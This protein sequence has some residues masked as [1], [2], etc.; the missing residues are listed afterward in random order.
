MMKKSK[1]SKKQETFDQALPS[2]EPS[3]VLLPDMNP[4]PKGP[5][6]GRN[7]DYSYSDTDFKLFHKK[8]AYCKK[9]RFLFPG[10]IDEF[11]LHRVVRYVKHMKYVRSLSFENNVWNSKGFIMRF[12]QRLRQVNS[13]AIEFKFE[14][15][16]SRAR[17]QKKDVEAIFKSFQRDMLVFKIKFSHIHNVQEDFLFC[18][19]A[20]MTQFLRTAPNLREFSFQISPDNFDSDRS[21][22]HIQDLLG[23]RLKH[24]IE[25]MQRQL[26]NLTRIESFTFLNCSAFYKSIFDY[27]LQKFSRLSSLQ[28]LEL[29]GLPVNRIRNIVDEMKLNQSL[30]S[31]TFRYV[32]NPEDALYAVTS[33]PSLKKFTIRE[34]WMFANKDMP[35]LKTLD[36]TTINV[37]SLN[38]DL[39]LDINDQGDADFLISFI[40]PFRKLTC[41]KLYIQSSFDCST[42]ITSINNIAKGL[43]LSELALGLTLD[44]G[45]QASAAL[46]GLKGVTSLQKCS[47]MIK[48]YPKKAWKSDLQSVCKSVIKFIKRNKKIKEFEFYVG[49]I[50]PEYLVD[51]TE[52]ASTLP[53][54]ENF[55]FSFSPI[56]SKHGK[57]HTNTLKELKRVFKGYN[58]SEKISIQVECT[59]HFRDSCTLWTEY[60]EYGIP[61]GEN[62]RAFSFVSMK[63]LPTPFCNDYL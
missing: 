33:L 20:N 24:G 41:L 25:T 9:L 61:M 31:L 3:S 53:S 5:I 45:Q 7:L 46:E 48:P 38:F 52:V 29:G 21:L 15:Y 11:V 49:K 16:L 44:N 18:L 36:P 54:L 43:K 58:A 26:Q 30:S 60:L 10:W 14:S 19:L 8:R 51:V 59:P 4:R 23:Q 32:L 57:N 1:P 34:D 35:L 50:P 12:M 62:V 47:L 28:H 42:L 13:V 22:I 37:T 6:L 17:L 56:A 55:K 27:L 63:E 39:P 2:Q 40:T